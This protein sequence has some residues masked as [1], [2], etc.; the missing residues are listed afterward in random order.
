MSKY[1]KEKSSLLRALS[2]INS[3][4]VHMVML[5]LNY[6]FEEVTAH[7]ANDGLEDNN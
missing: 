1:S 2:E 5:K 3:M 7:K 4:S 6:H